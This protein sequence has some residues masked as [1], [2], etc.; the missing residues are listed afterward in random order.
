MHP[1]LLPMKH[2]ENVLFHSISPYDFQ[3]LIKRDTIIDLFT[4]MQETE[5]KD[6]IALMKPVVNDQLFSQFG[7]DELGKENKDFMNSL[8]SYPDK[9]KLKIPSRQF[10][11]SQNPKSIQKCKDCQAVLTDDFV[12][13]EGQPIID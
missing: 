13:L 4:K 1:K 7:T 11:V 6:E 10:V 8:K 5:N 9:F 2:F 12:K 3:L